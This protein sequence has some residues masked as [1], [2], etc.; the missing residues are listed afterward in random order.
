QQILQD[1]G[2]SSTERQQELRAKTGPIQAPGKTNPNWAQD[3]ANILLNITGGNLNK[4]NPN[5]LPYNEYY[6]LMMKVASREVDRVW[7]DV[8]INN[9]NGDDRY[10]ESDSFKNT[11]KNR[12][13]LE[14]WKKT[15]AAQNF[16]D[17][18]SKSGKLGKHVLEFDTKTSEQGLT[19]LWVKTGTDKKGNPEYKNFR[20]MNK[21]LRDEFIKPGVEFKLS[22][23]L[24][25][26]ATSNEGGG[27]VILNHETFLWADQ[28]TEIIEQYENGDLND[29]QLIDK[30]DDTESWDN[31]EKQYKTVLNE[32]S[33]VNQ[34][35]QELLDAIE[36][37]QDQNERKNIKKDAEKQIEQDKEIVKTDWGDE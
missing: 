14:L 2:I 3:L 33:K 29:Q 20:K 25:L 4:L 17:R 5:S 36:K 6:N 7:S 35:N 31:I 11:P 10:I 19:E 34:A 18:W 24:S 15:N 16:L 9:D 32:N 26:P 22:I 13:S 8:M 28:I 21:K 27:A 1:L 30:L 37:I 23:N 12:N